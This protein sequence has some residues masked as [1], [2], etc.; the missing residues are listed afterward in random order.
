M[1]AVGNWRRPAAAATRSD[2]SSANE[3]ISPDDKRTL[4]RAIQNGSHQ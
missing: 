2:N 1:R 3:Q 4:D